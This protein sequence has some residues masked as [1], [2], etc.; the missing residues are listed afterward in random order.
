MVQY[1]RHDESI[2]TATD[3]GVPVPT[4]ALRITSCLVVAVLALSGMAGDDDAYRRSRL[5]AGGLVT[6]W[7][8]TID[9]W[10]TYGYDRRSQSI[11]L[12][13]FRADPNEP[14]RV[15]VV[16]ARRG[17]VR[18]RRTM[19]AQWM[20]NA[21]GTLAATANGIAFLSGNG[22]D[23][24]LL[25]VR[26]IDG[27]IVWSLPGSRD[28]HLVGGRIV[29][30]DELSVI[31]LDPATGDE[32][33]RWQAPGTCDDWELHHGGGE[34]MLVSCAAAVYRLRAHDGAEL[35]RWPVA[36][37]C[38][39]QSI[40]TAALIVAL[41]VTCDD[42]SQ[43]LHVLEGDNG[44]ELWRQ[45]IPWDPQTAD[46]ADPARGAAYVAMT[47]GS[48]PVIEV[49]SADRAEVYTANGQRLQLDTDA[50]T[51]TTVDGS[52]LYRS[53]PRGGT[54]TLGSVDLDTGQTRWTRV[55][56]VDPSDTQGIRLMDGVL[57]MVATLDLIWPSVILL[58][59]T[60]TGATT[61]T[62]VDR[63]GGAIVDVD[64]TGTIYA[65][66]SV[67]N[68][69]R[70]SAWRVTG[71]SESYLGGSM[72]PSAWPDA[73]T[74]LT[75]E[76]WQRVYPGAQPTRRPKKLPTGEIMLVA[77]SRCAFLPASTSA[78]E[79]TVG[80]DWFADSAEQALLAAADGF[81]LLRTERVGRAGYEAWRWNDTN[82]GVDL[83]PRLR[84]SFAVGICVVHVETLGDDTAL[85]ILAG[86][87]ADNLTDA[88]ITSACAT[89]DR[90]GNR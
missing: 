57:H 8:L 13:D 84:L 42:A 6:L 56:A 16:D 15:E 27:D 11:A 31:A 73:C 1:G 79:V 69:S 30:R 40:G 5:P 34:A 54:T 22:E 70:L 50:T 58:I 71:D 59:D 77:P 51:L 19:D 14:D 29:T 78:T 65:T 28:A 86:F 33:W 64:P 47:G 85:T 21:D 68:A 37:D 52:L 25:G 3:L 63:P 2:T 20:M 75:D 53:Q 9:D 74:L 46:P 62:A 90:G 88:A 10:S 87:V 38:R 66:V 81:R 35:W 32:R 72:K 36:G 45:P 82:T 17:F 44:R 55:V 39:P 80:L 41:T 60:R 83:A 89:R 12:V 49:H 18:W 48:T 26:L 23:A 76:Q 7:D 67:G 61:L 24:R 43:H 4:A